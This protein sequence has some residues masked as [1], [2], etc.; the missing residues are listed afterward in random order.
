MVIAV[1]VVF[2][3]MRVGMLVLNISRKKLRMRVRMLVMIIHLVDVLLI[4]VS[5]I[6]RTIPGMRVVV[7]VMGVLGYM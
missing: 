7:I 5:K 2:G 4:S 6:I 1:A 3:H